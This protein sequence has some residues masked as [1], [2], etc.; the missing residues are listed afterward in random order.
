MEQ[1][2][3]MTRRNAENSESAATLMVDVARRVQESDGYLHEMLLSMTAIQESSQKVSR[4]NKTIDEIAFQTNILALNAAVEAARAGE[5]GLG[6]AV[7][8]DE[9]RNLAQCS[10]QAAKDTAALVEE[11]I[12]R[13]RSGTAKVEQVATA[14]NG[15]TETV[16]RVKTL[17][18]EVSLASSQQAQGIGQVSQAIVQMEQVTQ[19]TAATAEESAAASEELNAQ[20]ESSMHVVARLATLVDGAAASRAADAHLAA[21]PSPVRPR[22]PVARLVPLTRPRGAAAHAGESPRALGDTGTYGS[23]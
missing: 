2:S 14:I 1:M 9:V 23:F 22:R 5:A 12:A 7:V 6:F 19:T 17:V 3:S 10:A 16:S 11:S 20:A 18:D 21:A 13:A 15:M 8:A 4:I